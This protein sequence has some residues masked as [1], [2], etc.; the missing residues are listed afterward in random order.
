MINTTNICRECKNLIKDIEGTR[1]KAFENDKGIPK[2]IYKK[3]P[4]GHES[5]FPT[6]END[7]IF[8]HNFEST[9]Y[10]RY[11]IYEKKQRLRKLYSGTYF[12][13]HITPY[14]RFDLELYTGI[15]D[16]FLF[17][18]IPHNWLNN[19]PDNAEKIKAFLK[20]YNQ[21]SESQKIKGLLES[22]EEENIKLAFQLIKGNPYITEY[23]FPNPQKFNHLN[24]ASAKEYYEM[25]FLQVFA[26]SEEL[27][28][29]GADIQNLSPKIALL[30][31]LRY[32][33][34]ALNQLK[35]LPPEIGD[36]YSLM[37]LDLHT[38]QLSDLPIE[39][40]QLIHLE[41]LALYYNHFETLP[42]AICQLPTLKSLGLNN[43]FLKSLP[44]EISQIQSLEGLYLSNNQISAFPKAI[45]ELK[46]LKYLY[47]SGNQLKEIPSEIKQLKNLK[48]LGIGRNQIK[49]LP[50]TL[51]DL[52]NLSWLDISQNNL[53]ESEIEKIKED[54]KHV[55]LVI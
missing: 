53:S 35:S 52:P 16:T 38:N 22:N 49:N 33:Y 24:F 18:I 48:W 14:Q 28:L 7:Y 1:C 31:N 12:P 5:V 10:R 6:Q 34:L 43:N 13:I 25:N 47:L 29:D 27:Y 20:P 15:S 54:L 45:L 30:Q 55:K 11:K 41:K 46:N 17:E 21:S 32:L 40:S 42:L 44:K 37:Y 19:I 26:S 4:N 51:E 2:Y 9:G 39:I 36:L 23:T 8:N 50:E 3:N